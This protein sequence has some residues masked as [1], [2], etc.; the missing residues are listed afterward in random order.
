MIGQ[1]NE[2]EADM[3]PTGFVIMEER[4]KAIEYLEA[5]FKANAKIFFR[6]PQLNFNWLAYLEPLVWQVW[7]T[8]LLL[9]ILMPLVIAM[10][11]RL[12][13]MVTLIRYRNK[14]NK[15]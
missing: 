5:I 9:M 14:A 3:S 6:N 12:P 13:P 15:Q 11:A 1:V 10:S 8:M 2:G 4:R 7:A